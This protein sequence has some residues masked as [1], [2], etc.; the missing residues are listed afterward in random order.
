MER[1]GWRQMLQ[2]P[3]H[4][5]RDVESSSR[6]V[7]EEKEGEGYFFKVR[8]VILLQPHLPSL[9]SDC[10]HKDHL[11]CEPPL[12]TIGPFSQFL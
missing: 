12:Q 9:P 5:V 7:S 8:P 1:E 10:R 6:G 2:C 11:R 4:I 3:S